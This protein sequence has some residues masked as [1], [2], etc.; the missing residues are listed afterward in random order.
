MDAAEYEL[1]CSDDDR[2]NDESCEHCE[3]CP[4]AKAEDCELECECGHEHEDMYDIH[5]ERI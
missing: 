1:T 2:L 3:N 5:P 4:A